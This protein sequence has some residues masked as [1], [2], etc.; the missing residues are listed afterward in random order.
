ME[1]IAVMSIAALALIVALVVAVLLVRM[2]LHPY[3]YIEEAQRAADRGDW[4][5]FNRAIDKFLEASDNG[6]GGNGRDSQRT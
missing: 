1:E 5:E 6:K 2:L 4:R 3:R